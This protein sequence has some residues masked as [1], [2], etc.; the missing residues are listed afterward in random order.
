MISDTVGA[1]TLCYTNRSYPLTLPPQTTSSYFQAHCGLCHHG[2]SV[3]VCVCTTSATAIVST[4]ILP[5]A[6]NST[7]LTVFNN[8]RLTR[9]TGLQIDQSQQKVL[10][11]R[12]WERT[13][14]YCQCGLTDDWWR[15][16]CGGV[17]VLLDTWNVSCYLISCRLSVTP[18]LE[19]VPAV[20]INTMTWTTC[21]RPAFHIM[22]TT[23]LFLS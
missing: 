8:N 20:W 19:N 9:P 6:C 2:L 1:A 3:C 7:S 10:V 17:N 13:T 11:V 14:I 4:L 12:S 23:I 15:F 16:S 22:W 5:L 21:N 18:H